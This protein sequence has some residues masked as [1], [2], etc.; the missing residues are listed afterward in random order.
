MP[1]IYGILFH[2][3]KGC[4]TKL[5]TLDVLRRKNMDRVCPHCHHHLNDSIGEGASRHTAIVGGAFTGK[6][7]YMVAAIHEL[8]RAL[9]TAKQ[10][11]YAVEFTDTAHEQ[12]SQANMWKLWAGKELPSTKGLVPQA[13]ILKVHRTRTLLPKLVYMYDPSGLI[14]NNNTSTSLQGYYRYISGIIFTIDPFAIPKFYDAHK[15]DIDKQRATFRPTNLDVM[16]A[17]ERMLQMLEASIG[18]HRWKRYSQP[19]AIV[20]TKTDALHLEDEI[21]SSAA[22]KLIASDTSISSESDAIHK[23][24]KDFLCAHDLGH[25][26][27]DLESHFAH[28]RYFSCSALGHPPQSN[29]TSGFVPLRVVD[30][31]VWLLHNTKVIKY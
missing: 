25:F 18:V 8:Q 1:S 27:R 28:V 21:G 3:C 30:P 31:L 10:H 17:Y 4:D 6:T 12:H 24:V 16:H 19:I 13:F 15:S 14:F 5:P 26:V 11:K 2:R 20:V 7:A 9:L 22:R 29:N 23:L